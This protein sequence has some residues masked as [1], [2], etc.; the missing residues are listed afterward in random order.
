MDPAGGDYH[1]QISSPAIDGGTP[2]IEF[3]YDQEGIQRPKMLAWDIGA[4]EKVF[5]LDH[6]IRL[7]LVFR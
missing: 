6:L 4:Y 1:L 3:N 5:F 7:P 2:L